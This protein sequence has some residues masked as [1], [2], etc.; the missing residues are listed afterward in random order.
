MNSMYAPTYRIRSPFWQTSYIPSRY[1]RDAPQEAPHEHLLFHIKSGDYFGTLATVAGLVA[2]AL[3][4]RNEAAR[5][6]CIEMLEEAR[7]DLVYLQKTH[8]I[9]AKQEW[10]QRIV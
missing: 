8:V 1:L 3:S 7:E 10:D 2:D 4:T 6:Q 5:E 9:K